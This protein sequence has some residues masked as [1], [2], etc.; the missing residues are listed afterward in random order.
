VKASDRIEE[1][2]W[3]PKAQR[4]SSGTTKLIASLA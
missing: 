4:F 1:L 3:I 2:W